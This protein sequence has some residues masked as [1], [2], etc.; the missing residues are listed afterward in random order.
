MSFSVAKT[1][2]EMSTLSL[3]YGGLEKYF[4]IMSNK[5]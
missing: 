1:D 5:S 3:G 4:I 2:F